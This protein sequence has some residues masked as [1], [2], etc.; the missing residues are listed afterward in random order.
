MVSGASGLR[1]AEFGAAWEST[2]TRSRLELDQGIS[3][4]VGPG[5]ERPRRKARRAARAIS[6]K[7]QV[8]QGSGSKAA[9]TSVLSPG[10][11]FTGG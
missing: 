6:N 2:R 9:A 5:A 1:V 7:E 10:L 8:G 4:C 3:R 11:R